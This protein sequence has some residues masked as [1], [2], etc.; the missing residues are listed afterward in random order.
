MRRLQQQ[1]AAAKQRKQVAPYGESFKSFIQAVYPSFPWTPHTERLVSI[2]QRIADGELRRVMIELP[3]RHWKS[4]I[5]SRFLPAYYLRRFPHHTVGLGAQTQHFACEFGEDA[6][7]YF[8]ASGGILS[9]TTAGKERWK[10]HTSLGGMWAAGVGKGTGLPANMLIVD[11]PIK[12][13]EE[14]ESAAHRRKV[15]NWWD[16][17]LSTREEPGNAVVIIHTRWHELDLIGYILSKN[18]ELER[19]GLEQLATKWHVISMP[20]ICE[21]ANDIKALPRTVTRERDDR[22]PG[23][24]LDP[25]R[26]NEEWCERQRANIPE[27]DWLAIYQQRPTAA[28]G[29]VFLR[30]MLRYWIA[31]NSKGDSN[32]MVR[33]K[34]FV[35]LIASVDCSFKNTAGADMVAMTLWGQDHRGMWLLDLLNQRLSFSGTL[36]TIK[37]LWPTWGFSE[38]LVEDKA[39]GS[40]VIDSLKREAAGYL[41]HEVEPLGGKEARANAASVQF[42]QGKVFIPRSH[43]LKDVYVSQ[44]LKFPSDAYDDLVD[45]TTQALNYVAGTGPM[46]VTTVHFGHGATSVPDV[47]VEGLAMIGMTPESIARLREARLRAEADEAEAML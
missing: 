27:R 15:H 11:D 36:E 6:R 35:R 40:A 24:A 28:G 21:A 29:T 23:E 12:G 32:D 5:F 18:E 4:T 33:P 10:T 17:V 30:E 43:P 41:V 25:T 8:V 1:E 37:A 46:R 9:T 39:N 38:L 16:S 47:N 22:Q 13:R 19:Q 45:S 7:N 2:G 20:A 31:E 34:Q 44:L 14:A 26:Y 42:K 3:P